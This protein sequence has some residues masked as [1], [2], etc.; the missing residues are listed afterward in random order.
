MK[1]IT[2]I[3][4]ALCL[5]IGLCACGGNSEPT[6]PAKSTEA[7]KADELILAIG[8][9]SLEKESVVLAAKAYYDTLTEY[10]KAQVEN[11]EILESA[12]TELDLVKKE[13]EYKQIYDEAVTLEENN[14]FQAASEKYAM[15]PVEYEDV[16][17]RSSVT[18]L[19]AQF[20]GTWTCDN[21]Y[22]E[23]NKGKVMV[24]WAQEIDIMPTG[25]G[26][27]QENPLDGKYVP[28][29]CNH[30]LHAFKKG[31]TE[32]IDSGCALILKDIFASTQV[33]RQEDGSYAITATS[34]IE[35]F[36]NCTV[37]HTLRAD[38]KLEVRFEHSNYADKTD[39]TS[40]TYI[41]SKKN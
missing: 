16:A 30:S 5:C 35:G 13:V 26:R 8:E 3:L 19:L 25:A 22:A 31:D 32:I 15:L 36:C 14:A 34:R 27:Y 38:G 2:A 37:T 4:L 41:Y 28:F 12:L 24:T 17:L 20:S 11:I 33:V 1:K 21:R 29:Q 9:V 40:A 18:V 10:Q 6:E 39:I 23:S 7:Q